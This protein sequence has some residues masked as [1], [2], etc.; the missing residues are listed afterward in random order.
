MLTICV[1]ASVLMTCSAR[2]Q[3]KLKSPREL[4]MHGE[5]SSPHQ[6]DGD[7]KEQQN[8][9]STDAHC[10]NDDGSLGETGRACA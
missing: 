1:Q 2:G 4:H 3:C 9:S 10:K 7:E 6:D 8:D 5:A